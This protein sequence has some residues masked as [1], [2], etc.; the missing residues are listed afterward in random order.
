MVERHPKRGEKTSGA[1]I[2]EEQRQSDRNR[3]KKW[4]KKVTENTTKNIKFNFLNLRSLLKKIS[5]LFV[6]F[7][8]IDFN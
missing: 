4:T 3:D 8:L 6:V 1:V 7:H 5:L 2:E